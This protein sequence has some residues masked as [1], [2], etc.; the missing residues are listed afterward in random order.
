MLSRDEVMKMADEPIWR[1][2]KLSRFEEMINRQELHFSR[3]DQFNDLHEGAITRPTF[4]RNMEE[5]YGRLE[6]EGFNGTP[7]QWR[8]RA[9]LP[10]AA[11]IVFQRLGNYANCWH[12]SDRETNLMWSNYGS[13]ELAVQSTVGKL[14]AAVPASPFG[15]PVHLQPIIYVDPETDE[16]DFTEAYIYKHR[17]YRAENEI[18][19]HT[20]PERAARES[21]NPVNNPTFQ[22]VRCDMGALLVSVHLAPKSTLQ[23]KVKSILT[24]HQLDHIPVLPSELDYWPDFRVELE[25]VIARESE[26]GGYFDKGR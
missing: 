25:E 9:L 26:R 7:D 14:A 19:A 6:Q 8:Q 18:R 12:L 15:R 24:Q 1:Y 20:F 21:Y 13:Q 16:M 23:E 4:N 10:E 11:S 22:K 17:V 5:W 2:M 3:I